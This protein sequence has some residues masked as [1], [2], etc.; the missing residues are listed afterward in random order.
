MNPLAWILGSTTAIG[1]GGVVVLAIYMARQASNARS[2]LRE[3]SR[4]TSSLADERIARAAHENTIGDLNDAVESLTGDL[5]R[6]REASASLRDSLNR[7][8]EEMAKSGTADGAVHA[9][10]G[11]L[12]RLSK[13]SAMPSSRATTDREGVEAVHGAAAPAGGEAG[14]RD[15]DS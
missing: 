15:R 13:L 5:A 2:D 4:L 12:D 7:A 8:F 9:L 11:A 10:R 6:E 14:L 3:L 1:V